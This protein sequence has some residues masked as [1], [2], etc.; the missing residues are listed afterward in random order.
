MSKLLR[1]TTQDPNGVFN[2]DL[3]QDLI[4]ESN[5]KIA[6]CNMSAEIDSKVIT[7][8]SANEEIQYQLIQGEGQKSIFIDNQT[9]NKFNFSELYNDITNKLNIDMSYASANI[10]RQWKVEVGTNN[11]TTFKILRGKRIEPT[12]E[13][14][15]LMKK[16][17][18]NA[19][20]TDFFRSG[21]TPNTADSFIYSTVPNSKG[22][23]TFRGRIKQSTQSFGVIMGYVLNEDR[24]NAETTLIDLTKIKYGV[25]FTQTTTSEP[26][27]RYYSKIING[28]ETLTGVIVKVYDEEQKNNDYIDIQTVNGKIQGMIYKYVAP[29][30]QT[31]ENVFTEVY[32]HITDLFPVIVFLGNETAKMTQVQFTRDPFYT[33]NG[34]E[35]KTQT[36]DLELP[37]EITPPPTNAGI[38][39]GFLNIVSIDLA[40]FMG[41]ERSRF[42]SSGTVDIGNDKGFSGNK[43]FQLTDLSDSYVIELMNLNVNSYDTLS[44]QR[45]NILHVVVNPNITE[46]KVSYQAPF[47]LYI[48]LKNQNPITLRNIKARILNE[49]LSTVSLSGFSM[50]T[51]LIN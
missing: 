20:N 34:I 4:I 41:F 30:S 46:E 28:V 45:S 21:G 39:E 5:S 6:L 42:P 50:I 12:N 2:C 31:V 3:N 32:D 37:L 7:I 51:L 8:N 15:D 35:T 22:T 48:S 17:N 40:K 19:S 38:T 36:I 26:P 29:S 23:S 18:I 1:L 9:Y 14:A 33:N 44:K 24:P 10:G 11:I 25:K 43:S 13:Y 47:P 16:V 49:D 27:T